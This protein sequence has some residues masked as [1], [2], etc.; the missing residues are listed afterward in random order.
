LARNK[1]D[2]KKRNVVFEKVEYNCGLVKGVR[3]KKI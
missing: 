2:E 1:N 3:E